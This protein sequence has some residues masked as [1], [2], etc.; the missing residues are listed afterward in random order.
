MVLSYEQESELIEKNLSKIYRAVDNFVARHGGSNYYDDFIQ[1]V[2]IVFLRYIRRCETEEQLDKFPWYDSI[3]AMS[4]HV[5]NNQALTVPDKTVRF[6]HTL[7]NLPYTVSFDL[8]ANNGFEIDGMSKHW[9]PD[10]DTEIDFDAFMA[11][12]GED[13]R[14]IASMRMYGMT[15]RQI[16]A[17][18]GISGPAVFK[19]IK[20]LREKFDEFCKGDD[21]D[22]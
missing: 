21:E 18:F 12:Q 19:K 15:D 7:K 22:E 6:S 17:Q 3:H 11:E 16:A 8:L 10:K 5:L 1:E 13:M 4:Q 9:V 20:K 14:R 2:S